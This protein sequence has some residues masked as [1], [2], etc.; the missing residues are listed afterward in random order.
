MRTKNNS[1][2]AALVTG[3]LFMTTLG[4]SQ[5]MLTPPG[6]PAPTMK[7]LGQIYAQLD[8]RTPLGTNT[9]PGDANDIF[10]ITQPGSYFLTT[11]IT[12]G[13]TN[14]YNGIEILAN[15]VT[16]DLN[17]F[18]LL[19]TA[20]NV[21]FGNNYGIYIPNT[22]TNIIVCNGT[23]NGWAAGVE[24]FSSASV[25]LVFEKLNVVNCYKGPAFAASGII[26]FGA[27]VIKGC[28]FEN[29]FYGI[30]CNAFS[31][32]ALSLI[33]DCTVNDS[34][35]TGIL[36]YGPAVIKSCTANNC[37]NTGINRN[38]GTG[39]TISGCAA[40]GNYYGIY[41]GCGRDR[42]ENNH[43]TGNAYG[44]DIGGGASNTNNIIIGNTAV[45]SSVANYTIPGGQIAG[46]LI[47]TTGTITNSNPWANFSF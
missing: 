34:A 24:S 19:S 1:I 40:N 10:V 35:G 18:A 29:D 23:I 12:S 9:T 39:G 33:E 16:L 30:Y 4:F 5:G 3:L 45:G 14:T 25:S 26:T 21:A 6:A 37:A 28:N 36:S 44:I 13:L 47:T 46:P 38:S 2:V 42:I 15:N 11:N 31:S 7:S 8:P 41:D 22:Q 43:V 20:T 27:A 17:G 32:S